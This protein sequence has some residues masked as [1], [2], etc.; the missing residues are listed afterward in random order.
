MKNKMAVNG[1]KQKSKEM[2]EWRT[3]ISPTSEPK[4]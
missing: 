4:L 1:R 2:A 3:E